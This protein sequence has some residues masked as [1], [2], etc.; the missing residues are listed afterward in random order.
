MPPA[1]LVVISDRVVTPEGVRPAAVVVED[2]WIKAIEPLRAAPSAR[3]LVDALDAVVFPGL[4]DAHVH[5]NEPG[6][7]DWEGFESGTRAAA[8]GGVTTVIDMPLNSVPATTTVTA[9]ALKARAATGRAAVDYSFWGGL[10]P[11]SE[12]ELAALTKA[13]VRGFKCFLVP[14]GVDEFPSVTAADLEPAMARLAVLGVPLLVHAEAPGVIERAAGA[15]GDPRRYATYLASRPPEAELEAIDLVLDL[16]RRTG[17]AVHVV[18][19]SAAGAL[20]PL[21]AARRAGL[22]VTVETCPHYLTFTAEEIP[23]GATAFKCAPPIRERDNRE[24]LWDGLAQGVIDFVASDHSPAPAALKR[25]DSGDFLRAWGGVSSLELLLSATWTEARDRRHDFGDLARWLAERPASLAGLTSK[26][27]IAPGWDADLVIW[28]PDATVTVDPHRLNHRH[29]VT[30]YEGK[31][32]RGRV[33][34]TFV[35]GAS[36]Y[37]DG[38]FP[39]RPRGEW[40]KP[41]QESS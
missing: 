26:G 14:S 18:H 15:P 31:T 37:E 27:R 23:D 35:R 19:L 32:L 8:A 16:C 41:T 6:R 5:L 1:D 22:P 24:R 38:Q 21:A 36:V 20:G 28:D 34:Q 12:G 3:R 11:G 33:L 10:V 4:V 30:P 40:A 25:L 7:S 17:C 2:G 9:L 39:G 13:G 29:P